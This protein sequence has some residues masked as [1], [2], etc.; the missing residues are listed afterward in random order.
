MEGLAADIAPSFLCSPPFLRTCTDGAPRMSGLGD[1][2]CFYRDDTCAERA[3]ADREHT[4][5]CVFAPMFWAF[6]VPF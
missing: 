6:R 2:L 5:N 4:K 3:S 1:G